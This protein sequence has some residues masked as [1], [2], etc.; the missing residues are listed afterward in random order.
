MRRIGVFE[1]KTHLSR[2]LEEVEA[3]EQLLITRRGRAV[4]RLI[5]V[6]PPADEECIQAIERLRRFRRGKTLADLSLQELRDEGRK[7]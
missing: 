3:G 5:P 1:A 7:G 2:L 6:E 4:A